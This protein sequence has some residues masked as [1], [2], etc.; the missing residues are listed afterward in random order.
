MAQ[1]TKVINE[2]RLDFSREEDQKVYEDY[3]AEFLSI[4]KEIIEQDRVQKEEA[5][6]G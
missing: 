4:P 1:G 2:L 6:Q 3:M 5:Q